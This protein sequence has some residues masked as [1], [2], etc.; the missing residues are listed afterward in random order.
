MQIIAGRRLGNSGTKMEQ[1]RH[2]R[3]AG[4]VAAGHL[5]MIRALLLSAPDASRLKGNL[6][7]KRAVSWDDDR[8]P[9]KSCLSEG[10]PVVR[11]P[12]ADQRKAGENVCAS[13]LSL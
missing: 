4:M 13:V 2:G 5:C 6:N 8:L 9:R 3:H 11:D 7:N 1:L 10:L 12:E